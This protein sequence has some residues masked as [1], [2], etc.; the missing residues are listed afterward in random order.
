MELRQNAIRRAEL[1]IQ[2]CRDFFWV[3]PKKGGPFLA[4]QKKPKKSGR[5]RLE[6]GVRSPASK[7]EMPNH[8]GKY[9]VQRILT[10]DSGLQTQGE[11]FVR[12]TIRIGGVVL[13]VLLDDLR[14]VWWL[15]ML[16]MV[17]LN[18]R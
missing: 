13:R 9:V 4:P 17:G 5:V 14:S 11:P 10:P 18:R 8:V 16:P 12:W 2:D 3:D 1:A 15:L 6:S 7:K